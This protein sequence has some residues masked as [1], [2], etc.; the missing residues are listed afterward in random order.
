M[1]ESIQ[2]SGIGPLHIGGGHHT[3]AEFADHFLSNFR[4]IREVS[5]IQLV[6]QQIRGFQPG[7]V[8]RHTV[9]V[10]QRSISCDIGG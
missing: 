4:M 1:D 9:L 5:Q 8:T 3:C 6:E 2:S 7:V 10:E